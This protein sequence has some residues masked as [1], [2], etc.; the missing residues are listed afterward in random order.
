MIVL[1][2][3]S[4]ALW[5]FPI[6]L[7]DVQGDMLAHAE[8]A[9]NGGTVCVYRHRW[10]AEGPD[11]DPFNG[12]DKKSWHKLT[13]KEAPEIAI[14]KLDK[15][16]RTM[17]WVGGATPETYAFLRRG[18]RTVEAFLDECFSQ[19]WMHRRPLAPSEVQ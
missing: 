5:F 17:A 19:P 9:E 12:R 13:T 7:A 15:S 8:V 11:Q 16:F 2:P 4:V 14:P 10:Y 6:R 18:D 3:T 1:G